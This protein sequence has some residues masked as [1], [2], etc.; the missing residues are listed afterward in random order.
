[1]YNGG[2]TVSHS[3]YQRGYTKSSKMGSEWEGLLEAPPRTRGDVSCPY[4]AT[5]EICKHK[6]ESFTDK[7]V[8]S[9]PLF[10][11]IELTLKQEMEML[12]IHTKPKRVRVLPLES[13][14]CVYLH[15][16]HDWISIPPMYTEH[17]RKTQPVPLAGPNYLHFTNPWRSWHLLILHILLDPP[18]LVSFATP[19][20][21][22][23]STHSPEFHSPRPPYLC[24]QW[25]CPL[26][27]RA[28]WTGAAHHSAAPQR[29]LTKNTH[30]AS[31][32]RWGGLGT[33]RDIWPRIRCIS[34]PA[35][36]CPK[37]DLHIHNSRWGLWPSTLQNSVEW[38]RTW[39]RW[40]PA[41]SFWR[42]AFSVVGKEAGQNIFRQICINQQSHS[43]LKYSLHAWSST[44]CEGFFFFFN[45]KHKPG[46]SVQDDLLVTCT[47]WVAHYVLE[48]EDVEATMELSRAK[49]WLNLQIFSVRWTERLPVW[50]CYLIVKIET[51]RM[52]CINVRFTDTL[53]LLYG[54]LAFPQVACTIPYKQKHLIQPRLVSGKDS[55]GWFLQPPSLLVY[56]WGGTWKGVLSLD[57]NAFC[58]T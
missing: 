23:V 40:G 21:H 28:T 56:L 32:L 51:G 29:S 19:D 53:K 43:Q 18:L 25:L 36:Q 46:G 1:M 11:L 37:G 22:S 2:E 24:L 31:N 6:L 4:Y 49:N 58:C 5:A 41:E 9:E 14:T 57:C 10:G 33:S 27:V 54:L 48:K 17:V 16:D 42:H 50:W 8:S 26:E 7:A 12:N 47:R 3:E 15:R 35:W 55:I 45:E 30:S 39:G 44:N 20:H 52:V 34:F 13:H 38:W